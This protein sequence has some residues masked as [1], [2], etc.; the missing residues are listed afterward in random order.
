MNTIDFTWN[1]TILISN[2]NIEKS[3]T[4]P[5]NAYENDN[6]DIK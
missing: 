6:T 3:E 2:R 5:V 4:V 1:D